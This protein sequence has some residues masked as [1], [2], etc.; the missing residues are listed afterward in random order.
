ML[1]IRQLSQ[2]KQI[3]RTVWLSNI[4]FSLI[5]NTFVAPQSKIDLIKFFSY[6]RSQR[7]EIKTN[8]KEDNLREKMRASRNIIRSHTIRSCILEYAIVSTMIG[9][10]VLGLLSYQSG[11][12]GPLSRMF[13]ISYNV[14]TFM[15]CRLP[16]LTLTWLHA[17]CT[18]FSLLS[19]TDWVPTLTR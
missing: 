5:V 14:S 19:V 10:I 8:A 9:G 2:F 13:S 3:N 17:A 7:K 11:A 15:F 12:F 18:V 1:T 6:C 4:Y 16:T